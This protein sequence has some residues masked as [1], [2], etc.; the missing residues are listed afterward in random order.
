MRWL[1]VAAGYCEGE[2]EPEARAGTQLA[3]EA[4]GTPHLFDQG[5]AD[6]QAQPG[7]ALAAGIGAVRLGK[8]AED[9]G[10]YFAALDNRLENT[11]ISR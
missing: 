11:C 2:L 3:V 5:F 6:F 4:H 10:E 7:A 8:G 9:P 1:F